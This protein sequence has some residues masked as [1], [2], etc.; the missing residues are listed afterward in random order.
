MT[1]IT[2]LHFDAGLQKPLRLAVVADLHGGE[3][4]ELQK[5][6]ESLAPHALLCPG[7]TLHTA[8]PDDNGIEFLRQASSRFPLFCSIGNH[9]V[10]HGT[11]IREDIRATGATLLD[12][13]FTE[14]MGIT[15]GGLSTGYKTDLIQSRLKM[16]PPPNTEALKGFFEKEGFKLLLCHHP[17]YFDTYLK[18]KPVDLV[19]SGHAHGGQWRIF[20]KG[21]F[22][23][24]QGFFPK[25]T[26]GLYHG[27]L[28]VSR[29]LSNNTL[30]PRIFNKRQIVII[31]L[32]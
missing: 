17:E 3:F 5:T 30:V 15:I 2:A 29:G 21:I 20:G 1:E 32:K 28:L 8:T 6:L 12:D 9:E 25:Y 19:V 16:P 24:G 23:P 4:D 27:R 22:A 14:F 10:K 13:N 7:D 26:S 31:E 18:D 11:D